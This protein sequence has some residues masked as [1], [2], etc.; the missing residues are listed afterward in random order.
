MA[1]NIP[2]LVT[3]AFNT[4]KA[5]VPDAIP[6]VTLRIGPTTAVNPVTDTAVTTWAVEAANLRPVAYADK[7]ERESQPV[8]TSLKSFAFNTAEIPAGAALDQKA[9]ITDADGLIWHAYR[10]E[11]DPTGSL[12]IFHCRR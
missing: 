4:A 8:E 10:A 12:V 6:T 3:G 2:A 9:E 11:P 5:L 1:L 7:K